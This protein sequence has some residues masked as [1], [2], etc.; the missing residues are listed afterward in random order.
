MDPL[1]RKRPRVQIVQRVNVWLGRSQEDNAGPVLI[2]QDIKRNP[3]IQGTEV[4]GIGS[5]IEDIFT[6]QLYHT[7][8]MFAPPQWLSGRGSKSHTCV[9]NVKTVKRIRNYLH[10]GYLPEIANGLSRVMKGI[11]LCHVAQLTAKPL[12]RL[13]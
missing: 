1:L 13:G 12:L 2:V 4:N 10:I 6:T 3:S 5:L 11:V 7:H 9:L 8:K